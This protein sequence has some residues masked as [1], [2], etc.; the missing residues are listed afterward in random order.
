MYQKEQKRL[1]TF[2][3]SISLTDSLIKKI[4]LVK[5][6]ILNLPNCN[7][8]HMEQVDIGNSKDGIFGG[9]VEDRRIKHFKLL[10]L[11]LVLN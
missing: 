2:H 6:Q 10:L 8:I 1:T 3:I 9:I 4:D 5:V 7:D 11:Y